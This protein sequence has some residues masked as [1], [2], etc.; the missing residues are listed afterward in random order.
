[1][2]KIL[3]KMERKDFIKNSLGLLGA[4]LIV[5]K[6]L[7][8]CKDSTV[9][10]DCEVWASETE[11]PFPTKKPEDFLSKNIKGDRTGVE[12]TIKINVTNVDESCQPLIG[13]I[14][15]IWHCDKD[16]NY[17]QYGG[18][19][20]QPTDYKSYKFL[21]GRQVTDENGNVEFN[22]IFPGWYESRATHIHV[23]IYD[24][25]G[26]SLKVTQIAFPE[27]ENSVVEIVN[28]AKEY[29][30]TKGLTGYTYNANDNV[31][32][33]DTD[34]NQLAKV[35]GSLE[36]GYTIEADIV[37]STENIEKAKEPTGGGPGIPPPPD[38]MP[39]FDRKPK[40]ENN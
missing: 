25:K 16:G 27:G 28:S 20:M 3:N 22:S 36:K 18:I 38:G 24:Q 35:S 19:R 23:H 21:R 40:D 9:V 14:V 2:L 34:G 6:V 39:P 15:D 26:K 1:M 30:Y 17:S 5:P 4:S 8:S 37:I 12:A 33:D 10:N 13:A 11:G 7:M 32:S 31:F 29:G